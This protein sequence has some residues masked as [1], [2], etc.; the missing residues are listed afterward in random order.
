[1]TGLS[2]QQTERLLSYLAK[3]G[4]RYTRSLGDISTLS[5]VVLPQELLFPLL[6]QV[7]GVE[8]LVTAPGYLHIQRLATS[9][10]QGL[11]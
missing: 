4:D 11:T 6:T 2:W 7:S 3:W 8:Y 1:M 5:Q 9:G 10:N